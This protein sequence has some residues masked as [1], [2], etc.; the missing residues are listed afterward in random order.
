MVAAATTKAM[1]KRSN[2]KED[3]LVEIPKVRAMAL[4]PCQKGKIVVLYFT[5]INCT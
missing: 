5:I 3:R 4:I 2:T 1:S